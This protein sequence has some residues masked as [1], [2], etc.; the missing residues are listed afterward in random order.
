MNKDQEVNWNLVKSIP[1]KWEFKK[2]K[3]IS[4]DFIG[5]GTPSTANPKYWNGNIA[6]MTSA[7]IT[8]REVL[9]GQRY[10]TNKGLENSSAQIVPKNNLLVATRVGVGKTA[11]NRIDVAI[12][13][14]LTG[15]IID[16]NKAVP[17]YLYWVLIKHEKKLKSLA[18]G[19]TIKGILREDLGKIKLILPPLPQQKKIADILSTVD[20][21]IEKVGEAIEKTQRLK[22]SLMQ[23]LLTNGV[24]HKEF[25]DTALGRLPKDWEVQELS[26]VVCINRNSIDPVRDFPNNE[27]FYIDID[28]VENETGL[29]KAPMEILGKNAPLR[30]RRVIHYNDVI[31]STVRPYLKAFALIPEKYDKQICSTGFAVLTC[32][33]ALLPSFL[34]HVTLSESFIS[35]CNRI[36]VGAQYP[37]LNSSQ[38][39]RL[40]LP[41]PNIDEQRKI[42]EI[43]NLINKR[44]QSEKNRKERLEKIKKGLMDDLLTGEKRVKVDS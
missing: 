22:K 1:K 9:T 20:Q 10:I 11:I 34:F 41:V 13:Q 4:L 15:V 7:H 18:Q 37:A 35:Q 28:S 26:E 12:S 43:L 36:M 42:A 32:K 44:W 21:A 38:V 8:G 6:W 3:D 25:K 31:M 19:S 30:A 39:S 23:E 17:D 40:K 14:D 16:E 5:G 24:G 2:L 29:V 33:E 27:F